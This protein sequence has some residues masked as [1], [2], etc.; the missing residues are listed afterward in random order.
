M[1]ILLEEEKLKAS[2]VFPVISDDRI[3]GLIQFL[4]TDI[5][6]FS[7]KYYD[8]VEQIS[9]QLGMAIERKRNRDE[10]TLEKERAEEAN[11]SKSQFLANMSHEIRTPMN[12]ILGFY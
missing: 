2:F 3:I 4:L 12:S 6:T 1:A 8:I 11:R 5:N 7:D 9:I 10:L